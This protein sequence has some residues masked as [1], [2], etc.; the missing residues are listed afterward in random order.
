MNNDQRD[1]SSNGEIEASGHEFTP[2]SMAGF[3]LQIGF[4]V[5]QIEGR[6]AAPADFVKICL[7]DSSPVT[8]NA[9]QPIVM[10]KNLYLREQVK[11][12]LRASPYMGMTKGSQRVGISRKDYESIYNSLIS[13]GEV[14]FIIDTP[15]W[16]DTGAKKIPLRKHIVK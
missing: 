12:F 13:S 2:S 3:L 11:S 5:D 4:T 15:D 8:G 10:L 16:G 14:K 9:D 6:I 7:A 1:P